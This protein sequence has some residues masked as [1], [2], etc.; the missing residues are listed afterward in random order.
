MTI[1]QKMFSLVFDNII[2]LGL[3]IYV[4]KEKQNPNLEMDPFSSADY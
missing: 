1:W 4:A 3:D 2:N